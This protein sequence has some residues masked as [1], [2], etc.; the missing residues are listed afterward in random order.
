[1]TG[2]DWNTDADAQARTG[3][4]LAFSA[5]VIWGLSPL[6]WLLFDASAWEIV[7][8]R[9]AY[10]ALALA[11]FVLR[12][13]PNPLRLFTPARTRWVLLAALL[14]GSNW[15]VFIWAVT[16]GHVLESSLGYFIGPLVNVALGV[17]L[18]RERLRRAQ[19]AAVALAAVGVAIP[20]VTSTHVPLIALYLA[21]SFSL[22]ALVRKRL[23]VDGAT[24]LF[25]ESLLLA[26]FGIAAAVWIQASGN[27]H[28]LEWS[29]QP[30]LLV[31]AGVVFTAG[32]LLLFIEGARR[33]KFSTLGLLQFI[34]PTLQFAIGL[35]LGEAFPPERA[36][37]FVL[38]WAG[39]GL[40]TADLLRHE[41][42]A[43]LRRRPS[44]V[45]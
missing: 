13:T 11:P 4:I 1:M 24:G 5:Y 32:V 40:Y 23:D 12:K 27:G 15:L 18:L 43:Y 44:P 14:I 38:I 36:A 2:P 41:R 20:V 6:Y 17:A 21:F 29:A 3:F 19:I 7:A 42:A 37:A 22:Y 8:H 16:N 45:G 30:F 35:M 31:S 10:A 34:T 33:L 25:L 28:F 39:L 9:S 26:P